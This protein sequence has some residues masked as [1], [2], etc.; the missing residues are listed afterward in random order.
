MYV[1]VYM[2]VCVYGCM[3]TYI[4]IYIYIYIGFRVQG[5]GFRGFCRKYGNL[6]QKRWAFIRVLNVNPKIFVL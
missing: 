4:Y 3:Y 2:C 5:S 1:C 6:I